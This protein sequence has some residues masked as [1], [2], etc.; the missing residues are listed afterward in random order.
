MFDYL[1]KVIE[2]IRQISASVDDYKKLSPSGAMPVVAKVN[3]ALKLI[4]AKNFDEAEELLL[5]TDELYPENEVVLQSLGNLYEIRKDFEKAAKYFQKALNHNP[6][7]RELFLRLGYAQLSAKQNEAACKTFEKAKNVFKLDSDVITGYGMAL[8]RLKKY[9]E[10]RSEF[11]KAFSLDAR[12]LNALFLSSTV[13]VMFGDYERAETRLSLLVKLA[14]N[15]AHLY[16]Y[17]KLKKLKGDFDLALALAA[18]SFESNKNF[19]PA[20]I[21]LAEIYHSRFEPDKALEWLQKAEDAELFD[22]SLYMARANICMFTEDFATALTSYRK[23]L[24]FE[25][26]KSTDMKI[27]V[28][29]IMLGRL[30][31][32]EEAVS[33]MLEGVEED[34][35]EERKSIAY[36]LKGVWEYKTDNFTAAEESF[37]KALQI[38]LKLPVVYYFLAKIYQAQGEGYKAEKYFN[39]DIEKYPYHYSSHKDYIEYL[40]NAGNFEEARFKIKKALKLFPDNTELENL[41][42][43][44]GFRLVEAA[45]PEYNVKE[46]LKLAEKLEENATFLYADEKNILLEKIRGLE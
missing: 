29:E 22:V 44:T 38:T 25:Q 16:E 6:I 45:T 13:D 37:R 41:L 4:N 34:E 27:L 35:C 32:K 8:Y 7:K 18:R 21:L 40:I 1:K 20:Y 30:E 11:V 26:D 9:D 24:E 15:T 46:L 36:M 12:N 31:G 10:A 17:A 19:L 33:A 14:P 2:Q 5:E 23:V 43:Y 3:A 39:L 42:F 28:C